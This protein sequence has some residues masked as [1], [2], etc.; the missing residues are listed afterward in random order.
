MAS[1][2]ETRSDSELVAAANRGERGAFE[3]LYYRHREWV[4]ALAFR[5]CGNEHDAHDVVQDA[6]F[7]FFNKFP[8][9][10][11]RSKLKTFL[12][13]VVKHLA[14]NR[15]GKAARNVA[16]GEKLDNVPDRPVRDEDR[17]RRELLERVQAL[18][19]SQR[20]VILLRFADGLSLRE[21]ADAMDVPL[22]TVKSRLHNA[23]RAL[24][25]SLG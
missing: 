21:I 25:D 24:R 2:Q 13:P 1:D 18:P 6:F 22:G 12:Y 20:E 16:L 4:C 9:F 10:E 5:F 7:Y 17:E 3:A 23:L 14:L 11:L 19:E 15:R 8:G